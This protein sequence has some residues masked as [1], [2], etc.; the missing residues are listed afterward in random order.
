MRVLHGVTERSTMTI[1]LALFTAALIVAAS[2]IRESSALTI[3]RIGGQN[4][5]SPDHA[6][7]KGIDFV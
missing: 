3:V 5:P 7:E 6:S 4:L 2:S 1:P